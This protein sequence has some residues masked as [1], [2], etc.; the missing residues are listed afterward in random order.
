M[1]NEFHKIVGK[2]LM[3][4]RKSSDMSNEKLSKRA[5]ISSSTISRY[6]NGRNNMNLD[7]IEKIV[8]CCNSN[9]FIF[10]DN[11]IA[12]MQQNKNKNE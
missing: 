12:K 1:N 3:L 5:G 8:L 4:L 11:C 2:E 6:E 9:I 7:V 10:F